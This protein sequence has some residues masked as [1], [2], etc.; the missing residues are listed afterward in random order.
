M[1]I[2]IVKQTFYLFF[3][4]AVSVVLAN[5]AYANEFIDCPE[6]FVKWVEPDYININMKLDSHALCF[7]GFAVMYSG[8]TRTP[9]WS[10]EHLTR[11]R[12]YQADELER[13]DSFHTESRLPTTIQASS[14]DY[15]QT[16]YDRGH[17]A[18]NAD[19]ATLNQQYDSFSLANIA[20]QSPYL[21]RKI[22]RRIESS[23]RYLTKVHGQVYVVTG[24][25][26]EQQDISKIKQLGEG[27]VIPSHFFKAV[28]IPKLNQ[29]GVYYAP[30]DESGRISVISIDE[31]ALRSGIDVM[32]ALDAKVKSRVMQLPVPN[33]QTQQGQ[34]GTQ[35][36]SGAEQG[37]PQSHNEQSQPEFNTGEWWIW[38]FKQLF[39]WL[40]TQLAQ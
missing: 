40:K 21:N 12:L 17:L 29:A 7:N 31:L 26:F 24:V 16:G 5:S 3:S 11:E 28:Y 4:L 15:S 13:E 36:E 37:Y 10:A 1:I 20:P 23:T 35:A 6:T 18:P 19:M 2:S 32:P 9:I 33:Q 38:F 30:N 22:W 8:I 39:A 34:Q 25:A 14:Q 27:V